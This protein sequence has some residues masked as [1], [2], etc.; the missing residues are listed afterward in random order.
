MRLLEVLYQ[1]TATRFILKDGIAL[2]SNMPRVKGSLV[3]SVRSKSGSTLPGISKQTR[4]PFT[5]RQLR[6]LE[7]AFRRTR[8]L[9]G[10][11]RRQL[12]RKLKVADGKV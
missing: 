4:T 5:A 8:Y 11:E 3:A 9:K 2:N 1:P 12:S 7:N 6:L 10:Q